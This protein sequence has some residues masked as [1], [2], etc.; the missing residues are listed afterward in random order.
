MPGKAAEQ[1]QQQQQLV[2]SLMLTVQADLCC[3]M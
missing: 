3:L 2:M 1:P